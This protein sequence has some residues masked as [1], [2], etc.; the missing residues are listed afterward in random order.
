MIALTKN[1][2]FLLFVT[3]CSL[4]YAQEGTRKTEATGKTVSGKVCIIPFEPKLY[5]SEIDQKI[6]QQT[7]WNWETIRENFRHQLDTQLKLKFQSTSTVVSFYADSA[8]MSKDLEYVYNSTTLAY[9]LI[10]KPTEATTASKTPKGIVNGQVAVE[11]NND[12]KFMNTKL[13]NTEVLTF[14]NKKYLSEYFVFINELDIKNDINSYDINTDTYQREV[15]VHYSIIDKSGKT[16]NAGVATSRFSSKENNP[17]KIV[18][19]CFSPIA[20]YIFA[21][22]TAIADPKPAPQKN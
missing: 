5:M 14:L 1:F 18:T 3:F 12:K 15:T 20:T 9:D 17:K 19:L 7:K 10:S 11:E 6:N 22:Y 4:S 21:K 13:S 2:L 16:I 8:K